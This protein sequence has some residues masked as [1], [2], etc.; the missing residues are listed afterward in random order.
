[1]PPSLLTSHHLHAGEIAANRWQPAEVD[2]CQKAGTLARVAPDGAIT[3][4]VRSGQAP[5]GFSELVQDSL[6]ALRLVDSSCCIGDSGELVE[7]V[8]DAAQLGD[9]SRVNSPGKPVAKSRLAN[10]GAGWQTDLSSAGLN[11]VP[12]LGREAHG[13]DQGE[14]GFG[15]SSQGRDSAPRKPLEHR[16]AVRKGQAL[17]NT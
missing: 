14:S 4:G 6:Q 15:S 7:V 11:L 9:G 5:D 17:S 16:E 8:A 10:I 3:V 1:M 13:L 12:F 2:P